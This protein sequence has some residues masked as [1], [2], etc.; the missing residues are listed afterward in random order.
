MRKHFN[1]LIDSGASVC[2]VAQSSIPKG[3]SQWQ[4]SP[5]TFQTTNGIM[6]S[7]SM[8]YLSD[9]HL[10]EFSKTRSIPEFEAYVY[11]DHLVVA[12]MTSYWVEIFIRNRIHRLFYDEAHEVG[13][14]F[15]TF[16]Q[17]RALARFKQCKR[18]A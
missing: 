4:T 11:D 14:D 9:V 1:A 7:C 3:I 18:F 12:R 8:V 5:L 10:P 6:K 2:M 17:A 16:P 15:S 13:L